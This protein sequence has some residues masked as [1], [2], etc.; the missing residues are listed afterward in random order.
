MI[1]G[2]V[3]FAELSGGCNSDENMFAMFCSA[4]HHLGPDAVGK[5]YA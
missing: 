4:K 3:R 1:Y 5:K 2:T